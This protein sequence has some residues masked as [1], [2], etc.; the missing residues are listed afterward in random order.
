VTARSIV[1]GGGVDELVAAHQLA[2][3]GH[4]LLVVAAPRPA[5]DA[6]LQVGWIPPN[7]VRDL[8]LHAELRIDTADPW[9]VAA[10]PGGERLELFRDTRRSADAIRRL[11]PRDAEK[12]PEFCRRMHALAGML[13]TLYAE[14]PPDPLD[15]SLGGF[16]HLVRVALR[17]RGL[18][19][20][21]IEDLLRVLP[22]SVA[23]LL[24]EWFESDALKGILGTAGVMHLCQGPR[25]GGT[26]FNFLHRHVGS[27]AGVFR[28]PLSN[29]HRVLSAPRGVPV[30]DVDV[31]QIR[32]D[33]GRVRGVVLANGEEIGASLVV[34]GL[35]PRRALLELIDPGLLDPQ[36]VRGMQR[37]RSRGVVAEVTL[38]IDGDPGFSMLSIAP[39]LDYLE[40]AYDHAKYG[41]ISTEPFIEARHEE[42]HASGRGQIRIHAQYAPY[43]LDGVGWDT[44]QCDKLARSVVDRLSDHVSRLKSAVVEQR[45]LAPPDLE[46]L[47]GFPEGQRF[48]A[49]LAL[50]QA[51]WMRP[52]PEL[53]RY[54]TPVHGLY[55][56]GPAMHPGGGIPGAAGANAARV[57]VSDLRKQKRKE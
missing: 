39:S 37:I 5:E 9:A 4:D 30:R 55:L 43:A 53:A 47:C 26:A 41:R 24:D 32:V 45:V 12:W 50:D 31:A 52:V 13:A 42:A 54:R 19:R 8:A 6:T 7:V 22:M 46:A 18:H 49:E 28:Q 56:C 51:L 23:D 33:A 2:R 29:I 21:G 57:I 36:L 44:V 16:G 1:I 3:A 17:M 48:H 38:T 15:R 10:L 25:S 20:Q 11:S 14:P 34:C 27:A 40:R 35:H